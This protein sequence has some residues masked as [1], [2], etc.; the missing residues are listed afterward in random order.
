[1]L[2]GM[3]YLKALELE[4]EYMCECEHVCVHICVNVCSYVFMLFHI[5]VI[6]LNTYGQKNNLK[7]FLN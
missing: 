3:I 2:A 6:A 5:P 4:L 1:M 7:R